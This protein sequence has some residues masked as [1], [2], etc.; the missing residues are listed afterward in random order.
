MIESK[1]ADELIIDNAPEGATHYCCG[2]YCKANKDF[3]YD[4][5][6]EYW[7]AYFVP[8]G[9]MRSLAD[10]EAI[11]EKGK[12]IAEL[13]QAIM[14]NCYD[15]VSTSSKRLMSLVTPLNKIGV[16][17]NMNM[18]KM[19]KNKGYKFASLL[20]MTLYE[21]YYMKKPDA[22]AF[23]LLDTT[24]GVVSQIDNMLTGVI[25]EKAEAIRLLKVENETLI[26]KLR[27]DNEALKAKDKSIAELEKAQPKW[28]S[29][30]DRLPET[31][32]LV[33]VG[34]KLFSNVNFV[35]NVAYYCTVRNRFALADATFSWFEINPD[36]EI[37][38]DGFHDDYEDMEKVTHWTP[39]LKQPEVK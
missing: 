3:F 18:K 14:S 9:Y 36:D 31:E 38:R 4:W 21:N 34:C 32:Q 23:E 35:F 27:D 20:A 13:E 15:D 39:L 17:K 16:T 12:K 7:C 2:T 25:D 24:A 33:L 10:I 30:D 8:D 5:D 19:A 29:V 37:F 22:V 6:G 26:A 1:T 28:I 11:V